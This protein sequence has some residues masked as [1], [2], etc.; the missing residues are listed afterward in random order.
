MELWFAQA[1]RDAFGLFH[2]GKYQPL[3]DIL[4][5]ELP[6]TLQLLDV[7]LSSIQLTQ[8]M[9]TFSELE[10]QH[11]AKEAFQALTEAGWTIVA[12]TTESQDSTHSLLK[13]AGVQKYFTEV[14]SCDAIAVTKPHPDV[15]NRNTCSS[16]RTPG[17]AAKAMTYQR[18]RV[19]G[20]HKSYP[21]LHDYKNFVYLSRFNFHLTINN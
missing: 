7:D 12:L 16:Q 18:S 13:R 21:R 8:I 20:V 19:E 4:Q 15:Y 6:R 14:F 17:L 10:L 5:A 9:A 2:A 11:G 3:K 1:L